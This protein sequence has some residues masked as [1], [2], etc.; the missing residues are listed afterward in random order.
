MS[1]NQY[2]RGVHSAILIFHS[3]YTKQTIDIRWIQRKKNNVKTETTKG[4][5]SAHISFMFIL[6]EWQLVQLHR[7]GA[8]W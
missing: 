4:F 3:Y 5:N 8:N 7:L 2:K 6:D 1:E